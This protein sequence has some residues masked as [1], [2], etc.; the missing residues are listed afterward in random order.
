M[1]LSYEIVLTRDMLLF[2][3]IVNQDGDSSPFAIFT[4][5]DSEWQL[6][7]ELEKALEEKLVERIRRL[8]IN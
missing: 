4:R 3:P 7:T 2:K 1:I 8:D 5:K 6:R